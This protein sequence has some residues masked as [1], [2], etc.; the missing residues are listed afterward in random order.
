MPM[1]GRMGGPG[2]GPG[3]MGQGPGRGPGGMRGPGMMGG[4]GMPPPRR[5]WG[6]FGPHRNR[7]CGGCLMPFVF[8]IGIA[9]LFGFLF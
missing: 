5:G 3:R 6:F 2:G 8:I 9:A 7:G 4:P 1:N